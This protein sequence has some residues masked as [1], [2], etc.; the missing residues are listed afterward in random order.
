MN[1]NIS[2]T[3]LISFVIQLLENQPHRTEQDID[4]AIDTLRPSLTHLSDEELKHVRKSVMERLS[5]SINTGTTI[6]DD[7]DYSPWYSQ[8]RQ[9]MESIYWNRYQKLLEQQGLPPNVIQKLDQ[10]TSHMMNLF[11]NPYIDQS[12]KRRGLVMGDVQ[13]GKTSNYIGLACKAADSGY[14]LI[15]I[16]AG[17][18]EALRKQTQER[19]DAGFVGLDSNKL[20]SKEKEAVDIGVGLIDKSVMPVVLTSA[21]RD[22]STQIAKQLRL[23]LNDLRTPLLVVIKKNKTVLRNF[24]NWITHNHSLPIHTPLLLIDDEADNASINVNDPDVNPTAINEQ[25]RSILTK[26]TQSTYV[27]FTATP[28]ANIFINPDNE[29]LAFGDDLF[30]KDFIYSLNPPSNYISPST[31]IEGEPRLIRYSDDAEELIPL[32]HTKNHKIKEL[33][34]TLVDAIHSFFI[35]TTIRDLINGDNGHRSML[36]NVSR[37]TNVQDIVSELVNDYVYSLQ[38]DIMNYSKTP[39]A[40]NHFRLSQLKTVF[41]TEFKTSDT[42]T[43]TWDRL[44]NRLI[45]STSSIETVTVHNKAIRALDYSAHKNNP[46][47]YRVIV[48]GGN[49]IS[50]GITLEGLSTSYFHRQSLQYDTLLQMGRWFGYRE[51]YQHLCRIWMPEQTESHFAHVANVIAELRQDL[52]VMY[53]AGARPYDFGLRVR[54]H[55]D[56]LLITARNKMRHAQNFNVVVDF[57]GRSVE[58]P[59]LSKNRNDHQIN[60]NI[61]QQFLRSLVSSNSSKLENNT[62]SGI[63]WTS[64]Y[65][66]VISDYI[67]QLLIHKRNEAFIDDVIVK[68]IEKNNIPELKMWDIAIASGR[69]DAMEPIDGLPTIYKSERQLFVED[70]HGKFNWL[71]V[72]S[73]RKVGSGDSIT[74][75]L[76]EKD[77]KRA[78]K[79]K[80]DDPNGNTS[81]RDYYAIVRSRPILI[82]YFIQHKTSDANINT[83]V[84][85]D[86]SSTPLVALSINFPRYLSGTNSFVTYAFNP[87]MIQQLGL[88]SQDDTVDE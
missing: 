58:T 77:I 44:L 84:I 6:V 79:M 72:S 36:I 35:T 20:L 27:G 23:R 41:D 3:Q 52:R 1:I 75:G 82:I 15:I 33:P 7:K 9:T 8:H 24:S 51:G 46:K 22:F 60:L 19:L 38:Q 81:L 12:W 10:N 14:K 49:A 65:P 59:Y 21:E 56:L 34:Q 78:E 80:Q 54:T 71:Q 61:T 42:Q 50:R 62:K 57:S 18:I 32:K 55:P 25:I 85:D 63:V 45:E 68:F 13:S 26:F 4:K 31:L 88:E 64:I 39:S 11:G 74:L 70:Q 53:E 30:P 40:L 17:T 83:K 43:V 37:F 29:N 47:G 28:F 76:S 2:V 48:I 5:V 86:Y 73:R 69:G 87:V 16:L 66:N 67:K